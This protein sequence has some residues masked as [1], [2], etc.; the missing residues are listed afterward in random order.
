MENL[1]S[2]HFVSAQQFVKTVYR[3]VYP[4][5]DPAAT[6]NNQKGKV[7]VITGASKGIGRK[8]ISFGTRL[9]END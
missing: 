1:P 9:H 8:V 3:D 5:I 7:I 2:D 6:S 4:A